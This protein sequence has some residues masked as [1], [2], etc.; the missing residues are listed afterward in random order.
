MRKARFIYLLFAAALFAF[1]L[2]AAASPFG[3]NDGG[4]PLVPIPGIHL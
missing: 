1:L 4:H 2:A 3:M